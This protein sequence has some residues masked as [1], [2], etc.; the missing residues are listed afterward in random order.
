MPRPDPGLPPLLPAPKRSRRLPG[1]FAPTSGVPIVLAPGAGDAELDAAR[2]LQARLHASCGVR[3]PIEGHVRPGVLGRRIELLR[4]AERGDAYRVSVRPERV[5][6]RGTGPA[7]LRYAVETL[8]QLPARARLPACEIEDAP[9]FA[10]RGLMLDVSRGK[11]PRPEALRTLVDLCARL[12]LNVLMLY[13]E[14][15]FR[16]RRHPRIGE[17]AS[18]LDAQTLRELDAYAARHHVELVPSLQ[19]LGHMAH[20]LALPPYRHLSETERRWTISP[21]E[22]GTYELLRDLLEEFLPNFR[23]ER[24]NA[25]C[26]EPWD[27]GQGRSAER[28]ARLGPGGVYLEHVRR[29]R[30]LAQSMGK[31]TLIWSDVVHRHP[32]RILEVDRDLVLLDWWY[33]AEHDF[34]RVKV[35]AESGLDFWVCPGTSSWN[36]LFPRVANSLGNIARYAAAGRRHGASGLLV[37]DWGDGGHYNLQGNSWLALGWAAQQAWSGDAPGRDFDRAF[38]RL[39]FGDAS[40]E[41]ARLYRALGAVHDAG[42]ATPNGSPLQYL[43]FDDLDS[44]RFLAGA[45]AGAL[46]RSEARLARLQARLSA[47]RT[48]FADDPTSFEELRLAADTSLL[49]TRKGLAGLAWLD[50]RRRPERLGARERRRL[51]ARLRRLADEQQALGRRLRALWL[52]RSQ[53]SNFEWTARR[54]ARSVRSLRRAATALELGR[55]PSGEV[56]SRFDLAAA[57]ATLPSHFRT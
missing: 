6:L 18:P 31:R 11:V 42:F 22:P 44:A 17:D 40:G 10:A 32:E 57:R 3:L 8:A 30:D 27:L 2:V 49:A 48:R 33:E 38:S 19:T 16:F 24:F 9:D 21:A 41:A 51:A 25:N 14:H 56:P 1:A 53:P 5:Q 7:G 13:V 36:C 50:W 47:A 54:L 55:P 35:F 29:V 37:T 15:T 52:R 28:S 4:E 26:D 34:D 23:S 12:K 46:R 45:R 43:Y 39:L 20:V